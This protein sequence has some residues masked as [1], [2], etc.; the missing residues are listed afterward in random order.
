M[1]RMLIFITCLSLMGVVAAQDTLR[2]SLAE[3]VEFAL[4]NNYTLKNSATDIEIAKKKIWETTAIGLPQVSIDAQYLNIFKVPIAWFPTTNLSIVNEIPADAVVTS[5]AITQGLSI[6]SSPGPKS[7]IPLGVKE[8]ITANL[9]VS[10][11]IFSSDYIVGLQAA[12]TFRLISEQSHQKNETEIKQ[13]IYDSYHL[14]LV[15]TESQKIVEEILE[16]IIKTEEEVRQMFE[17]GFMEETDVDQISLTR[18]TLENS[19]KLLVRQIDVA[20]KLLKFQMGMNLEEE[21]IL[22]ENLDLLIAEIDVESLLAQQFI[23]GENIDYQIISTTE[24]VNELQLKLEKYRFLPAI[25]G[26]YQHQERAKKPDFDFVSPDMIG[27]NL[28]LPLFTSGGRISRINQA[29]LKLDQ[30]RNTKAQLVEGLAMDLTQ[31]RSEFLNSLDSYNRQKQN[32][33]TS[34]RIYDRTLIKYREGFV[35][36]LELQTANNQYLESQQNYFQ[37]MLQLLNSKIKLNKILN[38]L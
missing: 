8:N 35:S 38:T 11:L 22:T 32:V 10:Q 24:K 23:L 9:V 12:K 6:G 34:K 5:E 1:K 4:E 26:F 33:E 19:S 3:A 13:L 17:A 37:D 21:I 25:S 15:L 2:F 18:T 7:P 27:V 31:S 30:I 14:V 20:I 16:N 36:S 28:Q 29:R